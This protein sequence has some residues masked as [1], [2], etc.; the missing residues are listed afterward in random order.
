M[1]WDQGVNLWADPSK[2]HEHT[3]EWFPEGISFGNKR[4]KNYPELGTKEKQKNN[5][6]LLCWGKRLGTLGG[7]Q[8]GMDSGVCSRTR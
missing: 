2:Q 4:K 1:P 7:M 5:P 6:R 8:A 3:E